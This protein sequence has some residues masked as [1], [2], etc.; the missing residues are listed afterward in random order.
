MCSSTLMEAIKGEV[1]KRNKN[2]FIIM[3]SKLFD[4][5]GHNQL[6]HVFVIIQYV[7]IYTCYTSET[8]VSD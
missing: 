1:K 7:N 5:D 6:T 8:N 4:E 2:V 3:C